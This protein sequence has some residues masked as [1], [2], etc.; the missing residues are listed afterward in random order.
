MDR[1]VVF[2]LYI[3]NNKFLIVLPN[4]RLSLPV[5]CCYGLCSSFSKLLCVFHFIIDCA[6]TTL[7]NYVFSVCLFC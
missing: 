5:Y 7:S 6:D 2:V 1:I 3:C 4:L